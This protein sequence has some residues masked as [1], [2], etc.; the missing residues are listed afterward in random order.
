MQTF[1]ISFVILCNEPTT[2]GVKGTAYTDGLARLA[3][4]AV[5]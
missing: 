3:T 4:G 5:N 1:A 2:C